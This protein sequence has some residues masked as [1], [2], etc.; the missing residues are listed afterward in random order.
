MARTSGVY[1]RPSNSFSNPVTGTT[2]SPSHADALFDDF[3][4]ALD[5]I[6]IRDDKF[7]LLDNGDP[8]KVVAF[9]VSG[10]TTG[11]T[12]TLTVPDANTTIVGTDA[13][14]TLTNKTLTTPD[15]NGGTADSLTS[16]SVRST[17]SAFDLLF[18]S[19]EVMTA[20][21]SISWGVA[22]AGRS[23]NLGGNLSF[24]GN[25]TTSGAFATT[26]T[27]TGTTTVTFPTTGTLATLGGSE[28]FTNKTL[29]SPI[30][31]TPA[32]GTPSA[33]VLT[34]CTGLPLTTGVTGNLPVANLNSGTSASATTFWRGDATWA[35][36]AGGG[37]V[38]GPG[39]STDNAAA[40]FDS[41]T[42]KLLQNGAL[43]IAD[44]TGAISRSGAGGIQ[45]E[46]TNTNDNAAA[47]QVGEYV[48]STVLAGSAVSLTSPNSS[49]VTT[50]SLTAGDWDVSGVVVFSGAAG[51]QTTAALGGI[52]TTSATLPAAGN[53]GHAVWS[54]LTIITA[55]SSSVSPGPVRMSLSGTTTVYLVAAAVFTTSTQSAYGHIHARRV[56]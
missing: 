37:D 35:T 3:E 51:T 49:N 42:G 33:G 54:S 20:N 15:I 40:R 28:T 53:A 4:T 38:V 21:R 45:Q 19:A 27:M 23:V 7:S 34:S 32:L 14:Q 56:R 36:P 6:N 41:T 44:T 18:A 30:F 48:E 47:G 24:A 26:F 16:L 55:F 25:F 10:V 43:L 8:T 9:Q 17:G 29:T 46:G 2:I 12:R 1:T 52:S 11:T 39:S 13:T 22:D 31:T 50:I 5:T